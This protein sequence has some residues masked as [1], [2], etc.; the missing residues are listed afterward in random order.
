MVQAAHGGLGLFPQTALLAASSPGL[1][2]PLTRGS[3]VTRPVY[4]PS[5]G[6]TK[7]PRAPGE[8]KPNGWTQPHPCPAAPRDLR[9][10]SCQSKAHRRVSQGNLETRVQFRCQVFWPNISPLR[11]GTANS[12]EKNQRSLLAP[13]QS[14]WT[15]QT[16]GSPRAQ[17]AGSAGEGKPPAAGRRP[18]AATRPLTC[19]MPPPCSFQVRNVLG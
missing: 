8:A 13:Q 16:P 18:Q 4:I 17:R 10:K 19:P 3:G 15:A 1:H 7:P 5:P 6:P 9:I 12:Q 2:L 11:T 14:P